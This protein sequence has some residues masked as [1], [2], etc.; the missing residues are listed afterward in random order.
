MKVKVIKIYRDK[1][2]RSLH[3]PGEELTMSK[4][5]FEEINS[6][7]RGI[8]AEEIKTEKQRKSKV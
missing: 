6:T 4:E 8:F 5:R 3:N 7:A 2:D 1:Y